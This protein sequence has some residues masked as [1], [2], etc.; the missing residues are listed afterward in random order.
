MG[1]DYLIQ[2]KPLNALLIF[3]LPMM[4]G[5]LFQQTYT[6]ADSCVVGRLVGE[7][8]LAAVGASYALTNIFICIAVGGGV[9][10]SVIVSRYFG[11]KEYARM[12][13]AVCTAFL[14]F[15]AVSVCLAVFGS[16]LGRQIMQ[17]L[18]TPG[19]VLDMAAEYLAIYF[20]GL[21]FL[22]KIGRAHV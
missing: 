3:A 19:D 11:A 5:N 13:L 17:A 8:A 7:D 9:G 21:P 4:I 12:K 14:S 2:K 16:L 20:L 18:N 10:A 15:L 1:N 22:F 6:M